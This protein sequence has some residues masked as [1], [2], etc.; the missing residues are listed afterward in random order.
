LI[1]K[2]IET[3]IA[4]AI[5]MTRLQKIDSKRYRELMEEIRRLRALLK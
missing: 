4:N 2:D 3:R 1:E 5:K